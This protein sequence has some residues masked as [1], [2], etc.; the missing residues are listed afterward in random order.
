MATSAALAFNV[1]TMVSTRINRAAVDEAARL[2]L[3]RVAQRLEGDRAQ[4]QVVDVG[5]I[6]LV[7]RAGAPA[8]KRGWSSVCAV[9]PPPLRD[10]RALDVH[11]VDVRLEAVV[12][13]AAVAPKVLVSIRSA[14]AASGVVD[15]GHDVELRQLGRRCRPSGRGRDQRQ[16]PR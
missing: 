10:A 9:R 14:P 2:L 5:G 8:T 15:A 13:W 16:V 12:A 11:L 3:E 1:S 6:D 7:G 4:R